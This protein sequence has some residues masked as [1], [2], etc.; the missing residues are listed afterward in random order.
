MSE[1]SYR[2]GIRAI[3]PLTPAIVAFGA[4]FGVLEEAS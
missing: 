1:G 2:D 3:L 4:S